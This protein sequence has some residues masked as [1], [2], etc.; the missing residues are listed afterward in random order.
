MCPKTIH[1][2]SMKQPL[3]SLNLKKIH[4]VYICIHI[5]IYTHTHT[6][7]LGLCYIV[8]LLL[9]FHSFHRIAVCKF[10]TSETDVLIDELG[11]SDDFQP[12]HFPVSRLLDIPPFF[13]INL[14]TAFYLL[15]YRLILYVIESDIYFRLQPVLSV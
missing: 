8:S 11:F 12:F 14:A 2:L 1:T 10:F 6:H 3:H 13:I 7:S 5:H 4:Y 9:T 15:S